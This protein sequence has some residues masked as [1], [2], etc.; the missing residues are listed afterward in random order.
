MLIHITDPS[1]GDTKYFIT[2]K[3]TFYLCRYCSHGR[4]GY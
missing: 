2:T 4:L 3:V 1:D